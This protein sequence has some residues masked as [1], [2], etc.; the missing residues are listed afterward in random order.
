M[1]RV[2]IRSRALVAFTSFNS[3]DMLLK[4]PKSCATW[5]SKSGEH[6]ESLPLPYQFG[7]ICL[8]RLEAR[9]GCSLFATDYSHCGQWAYSMTNDS[10]YEQA[11]ELALQIDTAYDKAQQLCGAAM[12]WDEP[13]RWVR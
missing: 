13:P 12:R 4:A 9:S 7:S 11:M 6:L 8:R 5:R 3:F 2:W 1:N 10:R